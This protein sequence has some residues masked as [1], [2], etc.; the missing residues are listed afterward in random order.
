MRGYLLVFTHVLPNPRSIPADAGLPCE[1]LDELPT[2][3]VYP[4]G[5]GAT[6]HHRHLLGP[7][8]G[9]SPRMRGYQIS[10]GAKEVHGRS[11]PADAGLPGG[12]RGDRGSLRVYPRGCGATVACGCA[13]PIVSGLSPR[14]RGYHDHNDYSS[15]L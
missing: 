4:R 11:I 15:G 13:A 10:E 1:Y 3:R 7:S 14:M 12:R 9:L 5:C 6:L 2:G 8:A